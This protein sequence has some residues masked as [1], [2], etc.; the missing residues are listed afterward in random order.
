MIRSSAAAVSRLPAGL[1]V[2]LALPL[3]SLAVTP[4]ADLNTALSRSKQDGKPLIVLFSA[5]WCSFCA[6]MEEEVLRSPRLD[7]FDESHRWVALDID[8]HLDVARRYGVDSVPQTILIDPRSNRTHSVRG[9]LSADEL[10]AS[11]DRFSSG[12]R[13]H[14][15]NRP[16]GPAS[17]VIWAPGGYRSRSI[18]FG[19]VGY[20]PLALSSQSPFQ[21]LRFSPLPRTPSTLA[22]GQWE[23]TLAGTWANLWAPDETSGLG[24]G[25]PGAYLLDYETLHGRA[26]VSYGLTN[27][28]EVEAAYEERHR[29]A[30][31]MD[32]L[33]QGFHDLFGIDQNGRDQV[34]RDRLF[35]F[36]DPAD[37]R[38]PI[39]LRDGAHGLFVRNASLT[40]QH[41]VTCG[42]ETWPALAYAVTG[43]FNLEAPD[44]DEEGTD[45]GLSASAAKRWGEVYAYA[46]LAAARFSA[47]SARGL[48]LTETQWS[49][50]LAGE[51]RFGPRQSFVVQY[52]LTEGALDMD[53]PRLDAFGDASHEVT[54]GYKVELID[55]G[56]LEFGL[57]ENIITFD[58]SPDFGIHLGWTQRF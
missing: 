43:R 4:T 35:L 57:V 45:L 51:W 8:R 12:S 48:S 17:P 54:L 1:L 53:S 14:A 6:T 16:A 27:T 2:S 10:A 11:V 30:G 3:A 38:E 29:F 21:S 31:D 47:T 40:V 42:T 24:A 39:L 20:G 33:I 55:R 56:V 44:L 32:G 7:R 26:T 37:G 5:R 46:S 22:R 25:D 50:L 36:L 13:E 58:N 52:L 15:E 9:L 41:N 18:C 23:V 28:V 19:Q 49:L 34:P